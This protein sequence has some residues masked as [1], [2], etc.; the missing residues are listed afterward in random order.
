MVCEMALRCCPEKTAFE[1]C[2]VEYLTVRKRF[3]ENRTAQNDVW[4][5]W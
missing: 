3:F 1:Q 5:M 2:R 4:Y